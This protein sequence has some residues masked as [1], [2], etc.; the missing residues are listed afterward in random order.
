ML[1]CIQPQLPKVC[2]VGALFF[3]WSALAQAPAVRDLT[4]AP[5]DPQLRQLFDSRSALFNGIGVKRIDDL[6]PGQQLGP[7]IVDRYPV[8]ELPAAESDRIVLARMADS[9]PY[10]SEDRRML[11]TEYLFDVI[12]ILKDTTHTVT[13]KK[14]ISMFEPGGIARFPGGIIRAV[15]VIGYGELPRAGERYV[16][17][18]KNFAP[19][20]CP[21]LVTSWL[22]DAQD[23]ARAQ[24]PVDQQR[25]AAGLTRLHGL[26]EAEFLDAVKREIQKR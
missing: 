4:T 11:F 19:I 20:D 8:P 3:T 6:L 5:T 24:L 12:E 14:R 25:A 17:F 21:R 1:L 22:I 15:H 2:L 23:R 7:L 16:L 10:I 26:S 9:R 13:G 18:L